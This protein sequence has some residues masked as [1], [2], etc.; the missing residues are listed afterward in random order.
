V[1]GFFGNEV[2]AR[3][4]I[5]AGREIGSAA[6]VADGGH[7]RID[8]LTSLSV[9]VGAV[10]VY[11]GVPVADP[12]VGLL[13]TLAILHIVWDMSKSIFTRLLDGVDPEMIDAIEDVLRDCDDVV[14]VTEVRARWL[15]HRL[16][17][18]VN[19]AVESSLPV[20]AAH[21]VAMAAHDKLLTQIPFL[22]DATIHVDPA[23]AS[24]EQFHHAHESVSDNG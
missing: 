10:A 8:G 17:A 2:V 14:D 3:I 22:S 20:E 1:I 6:L 21:T 12:I 13:I 18:E 23:N 16:H 5:N 19:I 7:A 15:G 9:L 24:G 11:A 4:R